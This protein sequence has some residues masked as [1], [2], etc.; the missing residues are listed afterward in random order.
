[1]SQPVQLSLPRTSHQNQ[2]L[3]SDYYL[4][5]IL[6]QQWQA[7]KD[8]AALALKKL[9]SIYD[10]FTPNPNNE[11]QT[12][13][14]WIKPV[15]REI[16][17][18]FF[19]VQ[20]PLTVPH[21]TQKPDYIFYNDEVTRNTQKGKVVNEA[22][23]KNRA[24]AIGDAKKWDRSLDKTSNENDAFNNKNPSYQIFFYML[25]SGL[26]WGILTNGRQWRL[27]HHLTAHKLD[28]FY[29]VDL[30]ALL[31]SNDPDEFLYFYAFFRK[32]AFE[33]GSL[34]LEYILTASTEF[35]RSVSDDLRKQV[36]DALRY[37][38]QGFLDYP[39]NGLVPDPKPVNKSMIIL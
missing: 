12:E 15:L 20:V 27:Y 38:A 30:P 31:K 1:M 22:D 34:S 21:G 39:D 28:V 18:A 19:D 36:Y 5:N 6:P 9:Q 14:D 23:L 8:E 17:H 16:G 35:A 37:V 10:K 26:P 3:F 2:G 24:Y 32:A 7:L 25:H 29:E 33:Q 13:D 11:A 4:D